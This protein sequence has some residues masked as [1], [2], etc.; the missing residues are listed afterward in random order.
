MKTLSSTS[1][2]QE[3]KSETPQN[4]DTYRAPRLVTLGTAVGLVQHGTGRDFDSN[5]GGTRWRGL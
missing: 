5:I 2:V 3:P 1:N 4:K